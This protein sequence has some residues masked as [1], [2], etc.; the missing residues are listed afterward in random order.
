MPPTGDVTSEKQSDSR[1]ASRRCVHRDTSFFWR[2]VRAQPCWEWDDGAY[3]KA[4]GCGCLRCG[5]DGTIG[6]RSLK[7]WQ[8]STP[9]AWRWI[10]RGLVA[11]ITAAEWRCRP[12]RF[13]AD[14]LGSTR[15]NNAP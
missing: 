14:G 10:G 2:L 3:L 8:D 6:S 12:I 1:P 11:I 13:K 7:A 15:T 5:K 4:R 9:V